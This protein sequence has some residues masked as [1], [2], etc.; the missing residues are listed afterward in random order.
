MN[1]EGL[2]PERDREFLHEKEFSFTVIRENND[3]LLIIKDYNLS[4]IYVPGIADL[5]IILP[6]GYPNSKLDMFWTFPDVKLANG[7]WPNA[8]D[9]HHQFNGRVW[10]RWSRHGNWRA[11]ID[12]L[13]NFISTIS[14]EIQKG[15]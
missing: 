5:L 15:I 6:A 12:S 10:Q 3:L 4:Q 13:K 11:G 8:A 9:Q 2:I 14:K 7:N 1:N